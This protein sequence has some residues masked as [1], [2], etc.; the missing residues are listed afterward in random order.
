MPHSVK[1]FEKVA[2]NRGQESETSTGTDPKEN[3]ERE[4]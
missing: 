3:Y 2:K 1:K 4:G